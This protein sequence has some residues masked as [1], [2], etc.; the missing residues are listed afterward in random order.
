M[1][2]IQIDASAGSPLRDG[3]VDVESGRKKKS[4]K[5]ANRRKSR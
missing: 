1:A 4:T 3:A 5:K 2:T